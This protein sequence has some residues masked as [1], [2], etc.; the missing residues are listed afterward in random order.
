MK[1]VD[2]K[3]NIDG[4]R[5]ADYESVD[6]FIRKLESVVDSNYPIVYEVLHEERV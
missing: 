6:D 2:L 1:I 3:L 5:L 4:L